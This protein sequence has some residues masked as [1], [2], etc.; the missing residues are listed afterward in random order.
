L[1]HSR[2]RQE[3]TSA[4]SL[5]D[6]GVSVSADASAEL[7]RTPDPKVPAYLPTA[8]QQPSDGKAPTPI[9]SPSKMGQFGTSSREATPSG[10]QS[11]QPKFGGYRT[12]SGAGALATPSSAYTSA[13]SS[14]MS[15]TGGVGSGSG[16]GQPS[17]AASSALRSARERLSSRQQQRRAPRATGDGGGDSD[18]YVSFESMQYLESIGLL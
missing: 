16:L 3:V 5:H 14:T 4:R 7:E 9:P 12:P 8:P 13:N 6:D 17:A 18:G 11:V 15:G 1:E 2:G 10:A